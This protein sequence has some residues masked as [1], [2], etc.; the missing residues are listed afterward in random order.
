MAVYVDDMHLTPIG[1]FGRMKMCHMTADTEEE[2]NAMADK[3]GVARK[4]HQY[5]GTPRSHYDIAMSKRSLAIEYGAKEITMR[6]TALLVRAKRNGAM[7]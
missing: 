6:E 7:A 3:I 2:L 5:P 1:Q 4:W